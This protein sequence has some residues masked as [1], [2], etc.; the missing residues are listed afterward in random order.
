MDHRALLLVGLLVLIGA[1][2]MLALG[3]STTSVLFGAAL[4][5]AHMALTQ[6]L[7]SKLIADEAPLDLRGT[8]FGVYNLATGVSVLLAS[9]IAGALWAGVGPKATFLAGAA[10]AGVAALGIAV[11]RLRAP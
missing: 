7:F 10:F 11:H 1:D 2:L 5:G 9:V 8:A 6:G 3:A 4:W